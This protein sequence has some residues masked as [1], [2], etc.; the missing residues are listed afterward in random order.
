MLP[1]EILDIISIYGGHRVA[2]CTNNEYAKKIVLRKLDCPN[3]WKSKD[4]VILKWLMT[5][6][7]GGYDDATTLGDIA[8]DTFSLKYN[9]EIPEGKTPPWMLSEYDVWF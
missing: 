4:D 8:W 3:M 5:Y 9:G 1:K 7:I 2:I 6:E